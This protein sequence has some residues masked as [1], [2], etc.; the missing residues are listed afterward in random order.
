LTGSNG[1]ISTQRV[2]ST[3]GLVILPSLS[4]FVRRSKGF[5][6]L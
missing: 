6:N 5:K 4:H 3:S 1:S 2:S